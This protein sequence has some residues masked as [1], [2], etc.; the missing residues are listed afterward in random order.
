MR[1]AI[2]AEYYPRARDPALGIW[3]HRQA[4]AAAAAG[5]D[6]HVLVLHRP[7][8]PRA[9][10]RAR[11]GAALMAPLRQP[12]RAELD[13]V[14]V[15]YVPFLAPPR[16]RSYG[17]WGSWAAPSLALALRHL[18]RSF[19]VRPRPRPLRRAGRRRRAARR[20]ARAARGLGPRWRP[21][22]R[23]PPLAGG[24]ARRA[25][26]SRP[27][28][29]RAR[30]LGRH[31]EARA[32]ARGEAHAR[33]PPRQ[34]PARAGRAGDAGPDRDRRQ[35]DRPQAPRRRAAR[36]VAAAR[37]P[38]GRRVG[39][40]R[41]RARA[42]AARAPRPRAQLVDRVRFTGALAP[43]RAL[44]EA[45]R[46]AVF[47]LPSVDEAFGVAYIEAMAGGVPAIG[48]RGEDGPEEIAAAGHG[49]R[50]VAPGDPEDL[51]REL[52]E[53]L[54]G[55][56][57]R[58][59]L[60]VAARATVDERV[61]LGGVRARDGGGVRAGAARMSVTVALPVLDGGP[62]L[63]EVLAAVRAQDVDRPVELLVIDSG[64]TRRL[65]R[66][67]PPP[68]RPRGRDRAGRVLAR[69]HPQPADGA[70]DGRP[71]GVP[72]AGLRARRAAA[73]SPR[74]SAA[75]RSPT[76]SRWCAG[77]SVRGPTPARWCGAR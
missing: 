52:G 75:S 1:V 35:P 7:V 5:A 69:R 19:R 18:R 55:D 39:G 66:A 22:R 25:R 30:E 41:R 2:V 12:L 72:H 38:P 67:R 14:P 68:R 65:A 21:A 74:C 23:R 53:L 62:R 44:E 6:V 64:S 20:R 36:A 56:D 57:W 77:R 40:R 15:T 29:R 42:R 11:D 33:R 28:R 59:E 49:I 37:R 31:G 34:R 16:P 10:L 24:N 51:A 71:R 4:V 47:V 32:G 13:G 43:D 70:G 26:R 8:P 58:R 9:A 3:A 73:G 45:R 50:L 63:G 54:A 76:T 61:H 17:T 27:R 46:G 60:G 48:C